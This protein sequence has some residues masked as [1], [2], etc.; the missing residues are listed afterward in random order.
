MYQSGS[1]VI[2][3]VHGVCRILGTEK[4]LVN[5]K[6]AEYLVLEPV[7]RHESKFYLPAQ[8]PTALEKLRTILSREELE[9]LLQSEEIRKC[10]WIPEENRRK[11]YYRELLGSGD[12]IALLKMLAAVYHY[13]D[14][15]LALGRKFH[16]C[17]DY[18]LR[19]AEKLLCSEIG[20]VLELKQD[21]AREYLRK[22]LK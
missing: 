15:Q 7:L 4:Q 10:D 9:T 6:R 13:K 1:Y 3:G 21:E 2:Y 16:Q 19:D 14:E 20:F 17:D 11:Q 18:F 12:R 5:R 8:N 22:H